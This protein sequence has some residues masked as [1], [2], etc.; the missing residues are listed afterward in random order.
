[1]ANGSRRPRG[2]IDWQAIEH[3]Y[4]TNGDDVSY[5]YLAHSHGISRS[6]IGEIARREGWGAKRKAHRERVTEKTLEIVAE[7]QAADITAGNSNLGAKWYKLACEVLDDALHA[8]KPS[9]RQQNTVAAGIAT[10][11]WRLTT[12]QTTAKAQQEHSGQVGSFP[13]P[14]FS[15]NDPVNH[16][17]AP[18]QG[19]DAP[20]PDDAG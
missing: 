1:M 13:V 7:Q 14:V 20:A 4:V 19:T 8:E 2:S 16:F 15:E 17:A 5:N 12:G 11:K 3:Q 9:D 18:E 10:E 6:A